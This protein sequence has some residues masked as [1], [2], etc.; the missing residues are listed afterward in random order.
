MISTS[1]FTVYALGLRHGADPD[2][3]AAIDTMTRNTA[4]RHPRL[5]RFVGTFFAGGHTVMV[6]AIAALVGLLGAHFAAQ[7]DLVETIGTLISIV[8]LL[9]LAA[10][11]LRQL[12]RGESADRHGDDPHAH[13]RR[14]P[15]R[16][17]IRYEPVHQH[18]V[19]GVGRDHPEAKHRP[20]DDRAYDA[21]MG[22]EGGSVGRDLTRGFKPEAKE[23]SD[24]DS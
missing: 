5:S 3:L 12:F 8:V 11:N 10:L 16:N 4:V 6:V 20:D 13:D 15:P 21:R 2:H 23:Q 7:S 22:A 24:D 14:Q 18:R 17:A 1:A 9:L 19:Q